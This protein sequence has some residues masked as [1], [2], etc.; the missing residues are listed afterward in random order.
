M[1]SVGRSFSGAGPRT[2]RL[3]NGDGV[4]IDC[5]GTGQMVLRS[6][7]REVG[8]MQCADE[9]VTA[10]RTGYGISGQEFEGRPTVSVQVAE[11]TVWALAVTT[12]S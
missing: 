1:V 2:I 6:G 5:V 4:Q 11:G 3:E 7:G 8:A 12:A 10:P 9:L